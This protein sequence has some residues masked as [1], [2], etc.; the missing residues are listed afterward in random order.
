MPDVLEFLTSYFEVEV[1]LGDRHWGFVATGIHVMEAGGSIY[2]A[3]P[4]GEDEMQ[5]EGSSFGN[6]NEAVV[7]RSTIS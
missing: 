1:A 3:V 4:G 5:E 6:R 2:M 7:Y